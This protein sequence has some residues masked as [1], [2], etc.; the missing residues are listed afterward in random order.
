MGRLRGCCA[1]AE[2]Q[3]T[4]LGTV[5]EGDAPSSHRH[6]SPLGKGGWRQSSDSWKPVQEGRRAGKG[7]AAGR[8]EPL[9]ASP[10]DWS[11]RVAWIF[12]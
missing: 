3:P 10:R 7:E 6:G 9:M 11:H 2:G 1:G 8:S 12:R 4:G 5:A